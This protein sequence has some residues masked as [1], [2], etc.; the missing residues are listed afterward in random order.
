MSDLFKNILI[1]LTVLVLVLIGFYMIKERGSVALSSVENNL[2]SDQL[3]NKTQVFIQ[4]RSQIESINFDFE[5]FNDPRFSTL[6]SYSTAVSEQP[7]GK[8]NIF[9][10]ATN[11]PVSN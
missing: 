6:V 4:R 2:V 10:S 8:S 9:D 7:V 11:I 1:V 5:I 3:L